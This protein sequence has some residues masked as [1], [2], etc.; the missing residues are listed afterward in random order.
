MVKTYNKMY[1]KE[2]MVII[3][4]FQIQKYYWNSDKFE[5]FTLTDNNKLWK[6]IDI[7]SLSYR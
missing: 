7:K 3:K 2:L 6:I 1:N 4:A 5:I